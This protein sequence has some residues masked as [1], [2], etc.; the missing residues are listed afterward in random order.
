MIVKVC[1][2]TDGEN[3]R[4]I[5][6]AGADWIGFIFYP[7]SPR[8]AREMPDYLPERAR[9]VGVFVNASTD[10]IRNT[11]GKWKLDMVQLHGNEL[12][13]Q[14]M[15]LRQHGLE[16]IKAFAVKKPEEMEMTVPYEGSCNYFLFDTPCTGYGGSGKAFDWSLLESYKGTTDFLLSGGL[17]VQSINALSGFSHPRWAG[18]DLNSGFE[19][20][21]GIKDGEAV[22]GFV[23][24]IRQIYQPQKTSG[25]S[26]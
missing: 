19:L 8:F 14:C 15:S 6:Q 25:H 18:V 23:Q 2:M 22:A 13:G 20:S 26:E 3:I 21:P 9:R 12:S 5:E 1:G 11:A 16:V 10:E 4:L 17:T 24:Q 7:P